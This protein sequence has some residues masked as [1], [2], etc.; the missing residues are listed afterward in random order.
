MLQPYRRIIHQSDRTTAGSHSAAERDTARSQGLAPSL[1]ELTGDRA[2]LHATAKQVDAGDGNGFWWGLLPASLWRRLRAG[3]LPAA[4]GRCIAPLQPLKVPA[5]R[6]VSHEAAAYIS[7]Q[8]ARVHS[9][10]P[11]EHSNP[12]KE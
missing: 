10:Q 3:T 8:H 9:R 11:A 12:A 4:C 5:S 2:H 1:Q 6:Q 7:A